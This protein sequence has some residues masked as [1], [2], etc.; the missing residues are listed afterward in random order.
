MINKTG[1]QFLLFPH[2]FLDNHIPNKCRIWQCPTMLRMPIHKRIEIAGT[3][4]IKICRVC[5]E[6]NQTEPCLAC[7]RKSRYRPCPQS[8]L[9]S[10]F[11]ACSDC[12]QRTEHTKKRYN[13]VIQSGPNKLKGLSLSSKEKLLLPYSP[14][15]IC[16]STCSKQDAGD[17][18]LNQKLDEVQ[19]IFQELD[20]KILRDLRDFDP[21]A[22]LTPEDLGIITDLREREML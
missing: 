13:L 8:K 5:Y 19:N 15:L 12:V 6:A 2:L 11:C 22:D 7:K 9:N 14:T 17:G 10:L 21:D 3:E 18:C 16:N 1:K 4:A 20:D